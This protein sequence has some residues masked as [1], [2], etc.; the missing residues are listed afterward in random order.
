[1]SVAIAVFVKTPDIS[2]IKTRL[3][4]GIGK[5]NAL[6]FY[7]RSIKAV[8]ETLIEFKSLLHKDGIECSLYWCLAKKGGE[9][10]WDNFELIYQPEGGLGDRLGQIYSQ[11]KP[12][13]EQVYFLGSDAPQLSVKQ[14]RSTHN[15]LINSKDFVFGPASDGGFYLFG[16]KKALEPSLWQGVSYSESTTL[17]E[18]ETKLKTVGKVGLLDETLTDVDHV[19]DLNPLLSY[20][21]NMKTHGSQMNLMEWIKNQNL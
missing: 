17:D 3:A 18:L 4:K 8:Q 5:A 16:G 9:E 11:L 20:L 12:L 10:Y 2:P 14:L 7:H 1:M 21:S 19:E 13:H 15:A 6:E